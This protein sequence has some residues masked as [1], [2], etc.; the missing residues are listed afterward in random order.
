[1]AHRFKFL[2][3][4]NGFKIPQIAAGL[5]K[6]P[7]KKTH[8]VVTAALKAGYRHVDTAVAYRNE[9]QTATAL[10]DFLKTGPRDIDTG[11]LLTREDFFFASKIWESDY[12][13]EKAKQAIKS[14]H[15]RLKDLEYIDLLLIHSPRVNSK[16]AAERTETRLGT[17]RALEEAVDDGLV[18]SIGVSNYG[19]AHLK[20]ILDCEKVEMVPV[21]N[22][23]ELHPWIQRPELVSFCRENEIQLE[24]YSPI[25][26]ATKLKDPTLVQL[27]EKYGKT[28]AQVL[29]RWSLQN[30]FIA[31]PKSVHADRLAENISVFDF[32]LSEEDLEALGS[33]DSYEPV[34]WDPTVDP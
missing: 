22:Q 14:E 16:D 5:Y 31:L 18:R 21:V 29:I 10:L 17:W 3:L 15:V 24:A 20:E 1:M 34:A 9:T 33:K 32:E 30:G 13:Y 27:A 7:P 11:K 23:V 25:T 8:A 28:P 19:V 4:N 12:G 2:D 6:V 26:H